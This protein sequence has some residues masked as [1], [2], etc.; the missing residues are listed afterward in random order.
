MD[1]KKTGSAI[2][3]MLF[4]LLVTAQDTA[5]QSNLMRS[6][7][8]IF[9]VVAVMVTIL[10]GLVMYLVRLDKKISRLEKENS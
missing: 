7:G 10:I 1:Y 8:R 4:S 3:G 5:N 2:L 6:N 9:V